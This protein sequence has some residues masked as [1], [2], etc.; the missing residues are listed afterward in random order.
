MLLSPEEREDVAKGE[1]SLTAG[2]RGARAGERVFDLAGPEVM[3]ASLSK[4][5][6]LRSARLF[7]RERAPV[8]LPE[9]T[10]GVPVELLPAERLSSD[11]FA[12]WSSS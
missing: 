4:T 8:L 7:A 5:A 9:A 10:D 11:S 6:R 3:D 1:R 2:V 12:V